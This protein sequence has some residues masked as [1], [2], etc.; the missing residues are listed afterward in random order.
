MRCTLDF[1][2]LVTEAHNYI[3]AKVKQAI[4]RDAMILILLSKYAQHN[5]AY[6]LIQHIFTN[7]TLSAA[8]II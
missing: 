2:V 7:Y 6:Q 8:I 4:V 1:C 5:F 3:F